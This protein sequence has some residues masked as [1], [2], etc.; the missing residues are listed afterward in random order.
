MQSNGDAYHDSDDDRPVLPRP[1]KAAIRRG[2]ECPYLDTISRPNLDFDFEKCCSVSLTHVN[3]Y[4]CLVC[5]KYFQGRG[6][7]THAYTHALETGHHMFM[8]TDNGS[9]YCLPDNYEVQVSDAASNAFHQLKAF[10]AHVGC[11]SFTQLLAADLCRSN[12]AVAHSISTLITASIPWVHLLPQDRSLDD[13]HHVL[14]PRFPAASIPRLDKATTW[15][16]ALDGTEYMP[17][18]VGLNNMKANDYVNVVIQVRPYH[19][20]R[21]Y[22]CHGLT[23]MRPLSFFAVVIG[24]K[25]A[26]KV[27]VSAACRLIFSFRLR[28]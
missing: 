26:C 11:V 15:T 7:N 17:G 18:L 16:Q 2:A 4:V 19:R 13:I 23:V 27:A 22:V 3:V 28:L 6:L 8:K 5:G 14:N 1:G 24:C 12:F 25:V 9:V 20:G 21:P 10:H